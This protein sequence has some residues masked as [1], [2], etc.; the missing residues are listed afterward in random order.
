MEVSAFEINYASIL[1]YKALELNYKKAFKTE[2]KY[3]KFSNF[4]IVPTERVE[5]IIQKRNQNQKVIEAFEKVDE[6]KPDYEK[7]KTKSNELL[8]ITESRLLEENYFI[9]RELSVFKFSIE[10]RANSVNYLMLKAGFN[11]GSAIYDSLEAKRVHY[12][13]ELLKRKID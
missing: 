12:T 6:N 13:I 4:R 2:E 5:S 8:T 9:I 11:L 1:K 3:Q 7:I 10:K